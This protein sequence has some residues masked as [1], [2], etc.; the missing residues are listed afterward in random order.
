ML[1]LCSNS[2]LNVFHPIALGGRTVPRR[3]R[4]PELRTAELKPDDLRNALPRLRSRIEEL[5]AFDVDTIQS[6]SD[7]RIGALEQKIDSTLADVF[8]EDTH[9]FSR[10]G[11]TNLDHSPINMHYATPLPEVRAG[12]TRGFAAAV[13]RLQTIVQRFEM[14]GLLTVDQVADYVKV[15]NKTVRRLVAWLLIEQPE[16]RLATSGSYGAGVRQR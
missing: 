1:K 14:E 5:R 9:E 11:N 3:T 16:G 10:F 7:P 12:V 8:G 4:P 2:T 15:T 6:R 13:E